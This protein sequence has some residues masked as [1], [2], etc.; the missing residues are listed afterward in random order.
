MQVGII[1]NNLS[2]KEQKILDILK[3]SREALSFTEILDHYSFSKGTFNRYLNQLVNR[4]L[5]LKVKEAGG[6]RAKYV[7]NQ[8]KSITTA[9]TLPQWVHIISFYEEFGVPEDFL[10]DITLLLSFM[11]DKF[12][13]LEQSEEL[14][15]AIFYVYQNIM[16]VNRA[17]RISKKEFCEYYKKKITAVA[18]EYHVNKLLTKDLG[19]MRVSNQIWDYFFHEKDEFGRTLRGY[20]TEKLQKFLYQREVA[21]MLQ[22][23]QHRERHS[24]SVKGKIEQENNGQ[25]NIAEV[26]DGVLQRLVEHQYLPEDLRDPFYA[27]VSNLVLDQAIEMKFPVECL[28]ADSIRKFPSSVIPEKLRGFCVTC[29]EPINWGEENCPHCQNRI[30]EE[31]LIFNCVEARQHRHQYREEIGEAT[32]PCPHCGF[33]LQKAWQE[34]QCPNCKKELPLEKSP[35]EEKWYSVSKSE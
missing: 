21:T 5:I 35:R 1:K 20:I 33:I 31:K 24:H 34:K 30:N 10:P 28:P 4:K 32:F 18:L 9:I 8:S 26:T 6:N 27:I 13:Q 17:L 16:W 15:L 25:L 3:S 11:G 23:Q 7:L 2:E 12:T 22:D 19:F 14:F 29:G